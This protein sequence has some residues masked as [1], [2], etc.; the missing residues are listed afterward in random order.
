M[1]DRPALPDGVP[2]VASLEDAVRW[3]ADAADA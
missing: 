2:V 3:V 1:V